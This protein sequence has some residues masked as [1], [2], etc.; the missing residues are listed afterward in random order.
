MTQAFSYFLGFTVIAFTLM[1]L[2]DMFF[3]IRG[4]AGQTL[5][6]RFWKLARQYPVVPFALGFLVG[7]LV[8]QYD[9]EM[10]IPVAPPA[11]CVQK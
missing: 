11:A 1:A 6:Y 5:S 7:H 8:W 10:I 2:A 3:F 9:P 4:G